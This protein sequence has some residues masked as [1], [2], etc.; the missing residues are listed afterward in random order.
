DSNYRILPRTPEDI[1]EGPP[2]SSSSTVVRTAAD[3]STSFT[4]GDAP[5]NVTPIFLP[6]TGAESILSAPPAGSVAAVAL[7]L[8]VVLLA[9]AGVRR[10]RNSAE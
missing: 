5:W 4:P 9:A 7:A 6:V 8:L 2:V 3:D 10:R 1:Y